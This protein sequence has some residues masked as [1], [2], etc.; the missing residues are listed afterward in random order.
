M[1]VFRVSEIIRA[2]EE[3][4]PN[5]ARAI[6]VLAEANGTPRYE[7]VLAEVWEETDQTTID[8]GIFEKAKRVAVVP[9]DIGWHDVGS[10]GRLAEIV[11]GGENWSSEEHVA[12][13]ASG[14]Y[15]W[16]PGKLVALIGVQDLVVVDTPDVLLITAKERSEEVKGI[17]DRLRRE[18]REDLL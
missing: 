1:F 8:Y 6:A 3:H 7:S 5:S 13:D 4:L 11:H 14:N 9:A 16:T 15:A 12:I 18:E 10:W 17:V 2:Y